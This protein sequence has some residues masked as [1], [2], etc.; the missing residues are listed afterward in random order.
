[1]FKYP[2]NI[3]HPTYTCAL[4]L[5]MSSQ[6]GAKFVYPINIPHSMTRVPVPKLVMTNVMTN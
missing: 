3:P 1:M 6:L 5:K 2:I 4:D